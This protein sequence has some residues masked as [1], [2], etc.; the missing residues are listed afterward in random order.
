MDDLTEKTARRA[1]ADPRSLGEIL[2]GARLQLLKPSSEP[3]AAR[4][5]EDLAAQQRAEAA[6]RREMWRR[7]L[8]SCEIP[9]KIAALL[10]ARRFADPSLLAPTKAVLEAQAWA[11]QERN[12]VLVLAGAPDASKTTAACLALEH[13]F[14]TWMADLVTR[15]ETCPR[16]I[17][18]E[19]LVGTWLYRGARGETDPVT[20]LNR[21]LLLRASL[22]VVDDVGQEPGELAHIFGEAL[23]TII[24]T[25]C[26]RGLRTVLTCND[27]SFE[28]LLGRYGTRGQR[29]GE[30]L[31]EHAWWRVCKAEGFRRGSRRGRGEEGN[32]T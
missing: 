27:T 12:R 16:F 29:I 4:E 23:D 5:A 7:S 20:N 30:R 13:E 18:A 9:T 26:N 2:A 3:D 21:L 11:G 22:L 6:D 1:P 15:A 10:V 24:A 28:A 32:A 14:E 25:R 8:L 31:T 17:Q 19:H